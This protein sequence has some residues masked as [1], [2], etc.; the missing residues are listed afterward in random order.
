MTDKTITDILNEQL[1]IVQ[2]LEVVLKKEKAAIQHRNNSDMTQLA[3]KKLAL[4]NQLQAND[5]KLA[6]HPDREQLKIDIKLS[7]AVDEIKAILERC[8]H[9]ND[10]NGLALSYA[11]QSNTKLRNLFTQ[12]RGKLSMTYGSDG[13]TKNVNTLGTNIKA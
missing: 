11:Q 12:S 5:Q 10:V 8:H 7:V 2:S 1:N 9:A 4:V 6:Q 13:Q 3:E